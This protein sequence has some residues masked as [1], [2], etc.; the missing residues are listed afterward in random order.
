MLRCNTKNGSSGV[1]S[2]T[3]GLLIETGK[4]KP[5]TGTPLRLRLRKECNNNMDDRGTIQSEDPQC[6]RKCLN[7]G[8]CS[9]TSSNGEQRLVCQ[10]KE[11]YM[12]PNCE[13]ALCFPICMNG[14]WCTS[15]GI[16]SCPVGKC[17]SS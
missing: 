7:G 1:A 15:P 13:T 11:G 2:L 4:G 8:R 16:C 17:H 9:S 12:G 14:G 3:I 10:C 6:D 5:L